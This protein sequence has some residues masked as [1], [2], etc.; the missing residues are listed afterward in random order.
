MRKFFKFII[1]YAFVVGLTNREIPLGGL[2]G[3]S[4]NSYNIG[5]PIPNGNFYQ[6]RIAG[7]RHNFEFPEGVIRPVLKETENVCGC[8]ILMNPDDKVTI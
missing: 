5:I 8:G 6:F 1:R 7:Q 2:I 4:P 3:L